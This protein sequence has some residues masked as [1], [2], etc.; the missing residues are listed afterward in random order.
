MS[1]SKANDWL[2]QFSK[3]ITS[4]TGEDG[5]LEKIFEI[6]PNSNNNNWC[7]EFCAGNGIN[8]SNSYNLIVNKGWSSVQIEGDTIKYEELIKTHGEN[9]QVICLNKDVSFSGA[10]TLDNIFQKTSLPRSFD[11]LSIDIDGND[12]Y[13]WESLEHFRPKVIVIEFNPCIPNQVDWVQEKNMEINQ[14]CSLLSLINLGKRKGYELI[15]ATWFNGIFVDRQ[16]Y[17]LFAIED[18]SIWQ[19][20]QNIYNSQTFVF[21]L[22]DGKIVVVGNDKLLWH[23]RKFNLEE[24]QE[25][26]QILPREQRIFPAKIAGDSSYQTGKTEADISVIVFSK[27][28]PLQLQAYLESLFYYS[29]IKEDSIYVLY[30][31]TENISYQ[32]L[33]RQYPNIHWVEET[34]F[35]ADLMTILDEAKDFIL[36]GCDDVFF[37][38]FFDPTI[39]VKALSQDPKIFGFGLRLGKNIPPDVEMISRGDYLLCNWTKAPQGYWSYPWEV[40]TSIYRKSDVMEFIKL[41]SNISNPNYFE[42][43]LAAYFEQTKDSN[44]QKYLACFESSKTVTLTI[45][46]V[47]ETHPNWFD[48]TDDSSPD[49]LYQYFIKGYK[50]NWAK[51]EDVNNTTAHVRSDYLEIYD[52]QLLEC[53]TLGD[54]FVS[55]GEFSLARDWYMKGLL[56]KETSELYA[57]IGTTY[58]R[59]QQW[60]E[61]LTFYNKSIG[62]QTNCAGVY[63]NL[64]KVWQHLGEL[65]KAINC[66]EKALTLEPESL[67]PE[68]LPLVNEL[69]LQGK[70]G[71]ILVLYNLKTDKTAEGQNSAKEVRDLIK[72]IRRTIEINPNGRVGYQQLGEA[73]L[74]AG[75]NEEVIAFIRQSLEKF[76]E[77]PQGYHLL[78]EVLVKLGENEQ[79]IIEAYQQAG[80]LFEQEGMIEKAIE[81][82][83]K[84]LKLQPDSP[85]KSLYLGMLLAQNKR[86]EEALNY[87]EKTFSSQPEK[88]ETFAPLAILLVKQGLQQQVINCYHNAFK[89]EPNSTQNYYNF[90]LTLSQAGLTQAAVAFFQQ[91]PQIQHSKPQIYDNIWRGLNQLGLLPETDSQYPSEISYSEAE[92]H[93][94]Q[95]SQYKVIDLNNLTEEQNVF[96]SQQ[97][98]SLTSLEL[99]KSN[100]I[101]LEQIYLKSFAD[102]QHIELSKTYENRTLASYQSM[103]QTGYIYTLCPITGKVVRSNQSFHIHYGD[104]QNFIYRFVSQEVFYLIIGH[105]M[106]IK[107]C[108]YFP[109]KDLV[110]W[111]HKDVWVGEHIINQLKASLVSQW[112]KVKSYISTPEP[113]PTA[114]VYGHISNIS[115]YMWNE[116]T[117]MQYLAVNGCLAK[118]DNFLALPYD[119]YNIPALFEEVSEEKVVAIPHANSLLETILE[120]NLFAMRVT[121]T[122]ITEALA[123]RIV[124]YSLAK[125]ANEGVFLQ[126]VEQAEK[127]FPLIWITIRSHRRV[128]V[129]QIEGFANIINK[130]YQDYP[131][132]GIVFDGWGCMDHRQPDPRDQSMIQQE[133]EIR[134]KIIDLIAPEITTYSSIGAT[135]FEKAV[136]ANAVDMYIQTEGA[137]LVHGIWVGNKPGVMFSHK[138]SMTQKG[139][140]FNNRENAIEPVLIKEEYLIGNAKDTGLNHHSNFDCD[141]WGIYEN[142]VGIIN[143]LRRKSDNEICQEIWQGLNG[144]CYFDEKNYRKITEEDAEKYFSDSSK[145]KV[146]DMSSLTEEDKDY[147][148]NVGV[149]LDHVQL[150]ESNSLSSEEMFIDHFQSG[151]NLANKVEDKGLYL[152]SIRSFFQ[153][154]IVETGYIYTA[155]PISG[156]ILR[157]NQSF[158]IECSTTPVWWSIQLYRFTEGTELFYLISSDSNGHKSELYFPK[159][160]LLLILRTPYQKEGGIELIN[161]FKGSV[162][163]HWQKFKEYISSNKK[164]EVAATMGFLQLP[165][166][167]VGMDLTGVHCLYLNGILDKVDKFLCSPYEFFDVHEVF[168]E[169]DSSKVVH[170]ISNQSVFEFVLENNLFVFR[171]ADTFFLSEELAD[172]I[173][174]ASLRKCSR[175]FL[176]EVEE[177]KSCFPLLFVQ[178][179]RSR[180]WLNQIEGTA[181]FINAL[182][183]NFPSLGVIFDGQTRLERCSNNEAENEAIK[184]DI[185]TMQEVLKLIHPEI[186]TYST[187]NRTSYETVIMCKAADLYTGSVGNGVVFPSWIANKPCV[188]HSNTA[189]L[190]NGTIMDAL[191]SKC[192]ENL[193]EQKFVPI[194]HIADMFNPNIGVMDYHL[195]WQVVYNMIYEE[196][197][198]MQRQKEEKG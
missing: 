172:R 82:Y 158:S 74:D 48:D 14:G 98:I 41:S 25:K 137:G 15:S 90:A 166:F 2:L 146:V 188:G 189:F 26:I 10:D 38:S 179:R 24:M 135:N 87:Y 138:Q 127:C 185:Q 99:V 125:C 92:T 129:S 69:K 134:L 143:S 149:C 126:E 21:Q 49:N 53:K 13:L 183:S 4:S 91:A 109:S 192:R 165:H 136:W 5:I 148:S 44:N 19:M 117:G 169:I 75:Q 167:Q 32:E 58:A 123:K 83:Q 111:F 7:V 57:N 16:Y 8:F 39:C 196:V 29:S 178:F 56:R 52:P 168:S 59:E 182:H 157:S 37:K 1:D 66:W 139:Y 17:D 170:L 9:P 71:E 54:I 180:T 152:G 110:I 174:T 124:N 107:L 47:Q 67:S 133:N 173:C 106:G 76:P 68:F 176:E 104:F 121:D 46:R 150:C 156:K 159:Y 61:A 177:A 30:Q 164:R 12:Y 84:A 77:W 197:I 184:V 100:N 42:G 31:P 22:F 101:N 18:N 60:S 85:D 36:W 72:L 195:D 70:I 11:L 131:K 155:C 89:Q 181:N 51:F 62:L 6:I 190:K 79:E 198:K 50:L 154:S 65:E 64:A 141:W 191:T 105:W 73:L 171:P 145:Y 63:R 97:G 45:N 187:I 23:D 120:N 147:L 78:G 96:L 151:F 102:T 55:Q 116:V 103:A 27:D 33:I 142:V 81:S 115:H 163:S 34:N 153:Q 35:P 128:W 80:K 114:V 132:L 160:D 3:N 118:I 193:V 95:T 186:K 122:F 86:Y 20:Y 113:K 93:F 28:R 130:L 175:S 112:S 43:E 88:V 40:S 144:L 119:Y 194:E 108:L 94:N 162:V 140:W 161:K